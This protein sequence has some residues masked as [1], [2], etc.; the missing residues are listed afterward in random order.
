MIDSSMEL[1]HDELAKIAVSWARSG[2]VDR[3]AARG[4]RHAAIL[5]SHSH[6]IESVP[7]YQRL[8]EQANVGPDADLDVL[9]REMMSTD[10]IF[11]SYSQALL[12]EGDFPAMGAWLRQVCDRDLPIEAN[13]VESIDE[14]LRTLADGGIHTVVSS[15]TSGEMSF[16]P[17]DSYTWKLLTGVNSSFVPLFQMR[18]GI[19]R[20]VERMAARTASRLM[21][22][23][24]FA[25]FLQERGL[26]GFDGFFLSF[27][28]G[29]QGTQVVGQVIAEMTRRATF[30]FDIPLSPTAV[31]QL[32]RG[33][34]NEYERRL[35]EQFLDVTVRRREENFGRI[36]EA[37][38]KST[39]EGQR[40]VIFGAPFMVKEFCR[41]MLDQREELELPPGS[42][43]FHGG[44]WKSFDGERIDERALLDLVAR[45]TGIDDAH[46][47]EGYSMT[48]AQVVFPR[49]R[50]NRFHVP[51]ITETIVFDDALEPVDSDD[52]YGALGFLDPFAVSYPGFIITGD[53]VQR[54]GDQ[55]PCGV[56]GLT[57]TNIGRVPGREVKGCGGIMAAVQG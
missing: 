24:R 37:M 57:I 9:V 55:C 40:A 35:T 28:G 29:T 52:A 10:H 4:T 17:R 20:P 45:A 6:Y 11:K 18:Q 22:P 19:G 39:S 46:V 34:T 3:D 32:V 25:R 27:S 41:W 51:P 13:E 12:D 2:R 31:R 50:A 33:V 42:F 44:G 56:D 53:N 48:E 21:K 54:H 23:E 47:S 5:A 14:W 1:A 26:K 16:V 38:R 15:G 30:L 8:A 49:C 7:A 36:V 43:L